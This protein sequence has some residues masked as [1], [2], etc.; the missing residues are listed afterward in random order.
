MAARSNR[1]TITEKTT[2]WLAESEPTRL[3]LAQIVWFVWFGWL[4]VSTL[5]ASV[6]CEP[7]SDSA[8]LQGTGIASAVALLLTLLPSARTQRLH[9][10]MLALS[11]LVFYGL[12]RPTAF[13]PHGQFL[14]AFTRVEPGMTTEQVR[15]ALLPYQASDSHYKRQRVFVNSQA[16]RQY[17]FHPRYSGRLRFTQPES[18]RPNGVF[19]I[20]FR[21]G[22]VES[23]YCFNR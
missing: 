4:W 14:R 15:T 7:I 2:S 8:F 11:C 13:S 19:E 22:R 12:Q 5:I 6:F 1:Q 18:S 10:L 23:I 17:W 21:G 16:A 9:C 20:V 3:F